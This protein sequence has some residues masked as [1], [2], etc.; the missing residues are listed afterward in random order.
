MK[1]EHIVALAIRLFAIVVAIYAL[2]NG[3]SLVPHF[4]QQGWQESSYLLAVI[5]AGLL[6]L[7]IYLWVFP[8]TVSRKLV[9]FK[10]PGKVDVTS[11]SAN[12]IQV[13]GFTILGFYL[14]FN[15]ISDVVY[16]LSL[17]FISAR[18]TELMIKFTPEQKSAIFATAIEFLFVLFLL[19]RTEGVAYV[20]RLL[21]Y[22]KDA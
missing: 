20:L 15:V 5:M 12:Q 2:T 13:V 1:L 19:V 6:L 11:A 22:G 21:R 7:A 8:L 4:Y 10:E 14:L 16:Y 3:V 18:N 17:V 9:E